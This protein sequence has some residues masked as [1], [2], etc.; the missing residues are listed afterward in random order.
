M[1]QVKCRD[2]DK[3]FPGPDALQ[4]HTA[5]GD[6]PGLLPDDFAWETPRRPGK[7]GEM[8]SEGA[9]AMLRA[10]PGQWARIKTCDGATRASALAKRWNT[11]E[12][13]K[14]DPEYEFKGGKYMDTGSAVWARY[15]A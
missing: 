7:K 4:R 6:C 2:C 12:V 1:T 14:D 11:V 13:E 3:V 5:S 15:I 8:P 10:K 9:L